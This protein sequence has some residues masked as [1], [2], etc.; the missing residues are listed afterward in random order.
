MDRA[1]PGAGLTDS[2]EK[3]IRYCGSVTTPPENS[4]AG[5]PVP[6]QPSFDKPQPG[7]A[8]PGQPV[9]G[10][11]YPGQPYPAPGSAQQP[12]PGTP[13]SP[14]G[15]GNVPY[16][17]APPVGYAP[18]GGY[19][20]HGGYGPQ[21]SY[22]RPP[23]PPT[24]PPTDGVSIAALV[25]GLVAGP[26]G[27]ILGIIALLRIRR[28]GAKGRGFAI[29]GIVLGA[30]TLIASVGLVAL[31]ASGVFDTSPASITE[32]RTITADQMEAGHCS[33][34]VDVDGAGERV[35]VVPC[36]DAHDVEIIA[37]LGGDPRA[38]WGDTTALTE[39]CAQWAI[40]LAGQDAERLET[41][42][43]PIVPADPDERLR[44]RYLC[45]V[46]SGDATLTGSYV[47]GDA[48]L[49]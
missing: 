30:L 37:D 16:P 6:G 22:G 47:V 39:S 38:H 21:G 12:Y 18:G 40:D 43:L 8:H 3:G 41:Y 32:A 49:S 42:V 31:A 33:N 9:P 2:R 25:C 19:G 24:Q 46:A 5:P 29:T 28:S 1:E 26:L 27:L 4:P 23:F 17:Q 11:A 36:S 44:T 35:P 34:L 20:P 14:Y 7:Q 48:A 45:S 13:Q 15:T 10:P